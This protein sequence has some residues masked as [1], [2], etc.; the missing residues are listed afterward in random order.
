[1]DNYKQ[2]DQIIGKNKITGAAAI[3]LFGAWVVNLIIGAQLAM[4]NISVYFTSYYR[5]TLGYDSVNP[6]TM[7]PI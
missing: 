1:M 6:D 3:T 7:F 5:Y 4:G 2:S